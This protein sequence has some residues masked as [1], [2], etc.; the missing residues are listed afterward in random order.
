MSTVEVSDGTLLEMEQAGE[1][2]GVVLLHGLTATRKYV[3]MGSKILQKN[4][5]SVVGYDARGH[6]AS[7]PASDSSAYG[8]ELLV[9]DLLAVIKDASLTRPLGIGISMGA[10]TLAAAAAS[11]P[12]LF[13]GL[14][15]I[16]PAFL[17]GMEMNVEAEERWHRLATGLRSNGPE[18]FLDAGA[19]SGVDPR[20]QD[21][22]ARA[23]VQRMSQHEHPDAVADAL[24][25]V[26][27][28]APFK[29]WAPLQSL[30]IPVC[31]VGSRDNADPG[32]PLA[33]AQEW[34]SNLPSATLAVEEDGESPLAWR[35]AAISNLALGLMS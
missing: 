14:V 28:S 26:P 10:H 8:Y 3:L 30:E 21:L 2:R 11:D 5:F 18:G 29:S 6:G 4:G 32:H 17:P 1:G 15:L 27:W 31:V 24:E 35:G 34:A 9:S 7:S 25:T 22:A 20:W 13:S 33:V 19:V 12:A 23:T 16:T